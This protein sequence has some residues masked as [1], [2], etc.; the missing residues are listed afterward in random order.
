MNE[1][2]TN[3]ES[4]LFGFSRPIAGSRIGIGLFLLAFVIF[5]ITKLTIG[6]VSLLSLGLLT[7]FLMS[8][9]FEL[10]S[11]SVIRDIASYLIIFGVSIIPPAFLGLLI[12]SNDKK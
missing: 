2:L 10:I 8:P 6:L 9:W 1:S 12:A 3:N 11:I 5:W 4:K 7:R